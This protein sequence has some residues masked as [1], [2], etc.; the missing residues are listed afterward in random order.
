LP[1]DITYHRRKHNRR[2]IVGEFL[3]NDFRFWNEIQCFKRQAEF[4]ANSGGSGMYSATDEEILHDKARLIC[5]QFLSSQ[6]LPKCRVNIPSEACSNVIEKVR[7]GMIDYSLFHECSTR[8]FPLLIHYWS[9]YSQMRHKYVPKH[10]LNALRRQLVLERKSEML[11]KAGRIA[12]PAEANMTSGHFRPSK[13]VGVPRKSAAEPKLT[14]RSKVEPRLTKNA[15]LVDFTK[16]TR[17][18]ND[19][20][21][22]TKTLD[23]PPTMSFSLATG[24]KLILPI[25]T[26]AYDQRSL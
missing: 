14:R 16:P 1:Y 23:E 3:L 5:D 11:I 10:K 4:I 24:I 15:P 22:V 8:I 21:N 7:L 6:I 2:Y 18:S 13:G 25:K 19:W 20:M 17:F 12:P 26:V 9:V